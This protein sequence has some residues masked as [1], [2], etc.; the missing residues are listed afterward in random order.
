MSTDAFRR[1]SDEE[2]SQSALSRAELSMSVRLL[3]ELITAGV[4]ILVCFQICNQAS[5]NPVMQRLM[6]E[7][8]DIVWDGGAL[9]DAFDQEIFANKLPKELLAAVKLGEETGEL[10]ETLLNWATNNPGDSSQTLANWLGRTE[11]NCYFIHRLSEMV[12]SGI[13]VITALDEISKNE[14]VAKIEAGIRE[15]KRQIET[16]ESLCEALRSSAVRELGLELDPCAIYFIQAGE[17]G[18]VLDIMLSRLAAQDS[19]ASA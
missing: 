18:G 4:P 12:E 14:I 5:S 6:A 11:V 10:D 3:G 15:A 8:N 7:S 13:P 9:V 19:P 2:V 17:H 1:P 16:G